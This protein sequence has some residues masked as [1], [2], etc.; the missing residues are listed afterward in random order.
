[1]FYSEGHRP[2]CLPPGHWAGERILFSSFS[3]TVFSRTPPARHHPQLPLVSSLHLSVLRS[4]ENKTLSPSSKSERESC[5]TVGG[6]ERISG[7]NCSWYKLQR[8][9]LFS[10][11][12]YPDFYGYLLLSLLS[13]SGLQWCTLIC[14]LLFHLLSFF[15]NCIDFFSLLWSS[16][17]FSFSFKVSTLL[18]FL[19]IILVEFWTLLS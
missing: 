10:A 7:S 16:L 15:Q 6:E 18:Y 13:F 8:Y 11:H 3:M 19:T 14:S 17:S 9:T 2:G 5:L 1:M 4:P 12:P